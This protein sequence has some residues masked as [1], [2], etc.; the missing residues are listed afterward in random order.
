VKFTFGIL[1][2]WLTVSGCVTEKRCMEKFPAST[3][4]IIR[5][6]TII[7]NSKSF[8]TLVYFQ[9]RDTIFIRDWKT[10]IETQLVSVNDS[11][12]VKTICP[13]DT[14]RIEKVIQ[15]IVKHERVDEKNI[16][17]WLVGIT[18]LVLVLSIILQIKR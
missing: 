16:P 11:V 4:T 6:T 3:E 12:F 10:K 9:S 7:T 1:F 18:I 13:G 17:W 14:I 15:N 8:D 2:I 5:D